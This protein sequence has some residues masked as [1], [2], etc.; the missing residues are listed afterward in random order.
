MR[1]Y[2]MI[3]FLYFGSVIF[4]NGCVNETSDSFPEDMI[5]RI[6]GN[7]YQNEETPEITALAEHE[8]KMEVLWY[9]EPPSCTQGGYRIEMCSECDWVDDM[10][11]GSVPPLE[12]E[13]TAEELHHGNCVEDTIIVYICK[14]C[15]EQIKYERHPEQEEHKWIYKT[16]T[17]W[18]EESRSF[19]EERICCCERCDTVLF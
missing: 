5:D 15:N 18:D 17:V 8:H 10:G 13:L 9:G 19:R 1:K 2:L 6:A 11:S 7:I 12:H 16:I 4:L 3:L 14:N